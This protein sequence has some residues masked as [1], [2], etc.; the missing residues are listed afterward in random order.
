MQELSKSC[1]N[2]YLRRSLKSDF[3]T[4]T[5]QPFRARLPLVTAWLVLP[6]VVKIGLFG[7]F[8][9]LELLDI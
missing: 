1:K 7:S 3:E 9:R 5:Q 4:L 2:Q 8:V 6:H